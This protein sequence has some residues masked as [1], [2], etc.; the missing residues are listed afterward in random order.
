MI[1]ERCPPNGL[2]RAA[3]FVREAAEWEDAG[4]LDR[5]AHCRRVA[6]DIEQTEF[7]SRP[8]LALMGKPG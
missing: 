8:L 4:N 5:A 7:S 2:A 1:T 3:W 6:A